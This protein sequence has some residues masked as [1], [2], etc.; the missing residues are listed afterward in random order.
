MSVRRT[1]DMQLVMAIYHTPLGPNPDF[2]AIQLLSSILGDTPSGRLHKTL[3][4]TKQ[5]AEVFSA[6]FV[7]REPSVVFFGAE[8]PKTDSLDTAKATLV[9]PIEGLAKEPVTDA[10]DDGASTK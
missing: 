10:A 9:A 2:A 4:E 6:A 7:W 5:A 1:V 8:L 3:V